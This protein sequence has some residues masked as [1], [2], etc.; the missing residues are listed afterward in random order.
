[1][2]DL[3]RYEEFD[4]EPLSPLSSVW[5]VFGNGS[6]FALLSASRDVA[7]HVAEALTSRVRIR[8]VVADFAAGVLPPDDALARITEI[9]AVRPLVQA[10]GFRR[11][12]RPKPPDGFHFEAVEDSSLTW[13]TPPL[14][15][16]GCRFT[17]G[18]GHKTCGAEPV[19]SLMRGSGTPWNYCREHLYGRWVEGGRV[20]GWRAVRDSPGP[21]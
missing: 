16:G 7:E 19:A 17:V 11:P 20:M 13:K 3:D 14:S 12:P 6:N 2:S 10:G 5:A 8:A 1:M 21:G 15:A 4:A 9:V 18:P